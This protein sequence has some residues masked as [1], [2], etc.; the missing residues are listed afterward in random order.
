MAS[1]T[2]V[3]SHKILCKLDV[4]IQ[5]VFFRHIIKKRSAKLAYIFKTASIL[6]KF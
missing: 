3:W 4:V 5:W 2:R 1:S 6:E